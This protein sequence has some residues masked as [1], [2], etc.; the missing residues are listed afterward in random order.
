MKTLE[1]S[2]FIV[3]LT[4]KSQS[5]FW[6]SFLTGEKVEFLLTAEASQMRTFRHAV[7]LSLKPGFSVSPGHGHVEVVRAREKLPHRWVSGYERGKTLP[8]NNA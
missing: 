5:V 8:K 4:I 1:Q 2:S 7:G 3:G 6:Y